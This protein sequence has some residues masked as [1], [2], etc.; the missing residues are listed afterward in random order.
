[1]PSISRTCLSLLLV[2]SAASTYAKTTVAVLELGSGGAV[3][4]T[5]SS[6]EKQTT[7]TGVESFWSNLHNLR[8][9]RYHQAQEPG[10][11]LVPDM[12]NKADSGIVI[13]LMGKGM[14]LSSMKTV[15]SLLDIDASIATGHLEMAGNKAGTLMRKTKIIEDVDQFES[16]LKNSADKLL[17]EKGKKFQTVAM[18]LN[19]ESS[20]SSSNVDNQISATIESLRKEAEAS[21][22]KIVV[23]VIVEK[24]EHNYK[25]RYLED[26]ED[27][28]GDGEDQDGSLYYGYGYF[29]DNGEYYTPYRTIFQI[30]YFN[31]ILW[32]AV[33]LVILLSYTISM[34][35]N[36]PLLPD[37]L[38]FGESAKMFAD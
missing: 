31:C 16:A 6:I 12:F 32:A 7:V 33:G 28:D 20:S 18:Q 10:M 4:Q 19:D 1:M 38:L 2:A 37:T 14:D 24:Q 3:R 21:N 29:L 25:G 8:P 27:E 26:K 5:T 13:A 30:Q 36:M 34:T 15:S 9:K 22:S 23:H 17:S 35:L 11:S